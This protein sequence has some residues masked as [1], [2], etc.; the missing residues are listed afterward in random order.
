MVHSYLAGED[1]VGHGTDAGHD[2]KLAQE[3]QEIN[4]IV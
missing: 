3:E 4:D 1:E 2:D